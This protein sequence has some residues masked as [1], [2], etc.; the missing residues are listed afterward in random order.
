MHSEV[1]LVEDKFH[2]ECGVFGIYSASKMDAARYAYYG[3]YALQHRGQGSAGI[4][5][6][7]NGAISFYKDMGL[8]GEIF[9]DDILERLKGSSAVGH[10]RY[11][12][13]G[14]SMRE[15]AQPMV[16]KYRSGSIALAHNGN[17]VNSGQLRDKLEEQG[18]IFQSTIDSEVI[19]YLIS[20]YR[21][22]NENVEESIRQAMKEIEGSYALIVLTSTKLV[23]VRDPYGIRPLCVGK[24]GDA[25]V[26]SSESCAL[27]AIG[28]EFIRDVNPG[29]IVIAE[30]AGLRSIQTEPVGEGNVC[31]FEHIYF[32]RPDSFIDGVS[33]NMARIE[34][35][36]Q[37]AI[38]YPVDADLVTGVPD[39]G[40]S[41]ALGYSRQS[42]IPYG[43]GLIKNRY[44][45]RTFIQSKKTQRDTSVRI[46]LSAMK[47]AVNGKRVV[48]V[49]DS[50]VRG[51]TSRR[52]VQILR[53]AGAKEV[54]MRIASP[55]VNYPCYF[56]IDTPSRTQLVA[57][58]CSVEEIK[59]LVGADTLGYLT[60]ETL[61]KTAVGSKC[62]FCTACFDGNYPMD[63]PGEGHKSN[64]D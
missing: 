19:A 8:V 33:V 4:A 59:E 7:D 35:G 52:I 50:I 12:T 53:D 17:L 20:K 36:R 34:A 2:D 61:L 42:G 31:I 32:A 41:A 58:R 25:Y 29:E 40:L 9:R 6:C 57:S 26:F 30:R 44:I 27:D 3:L 39:S 21:T 16:I 10:V 60:V 5:V 51:T 45:G 14:A 54:H 23:G 22:V 11:S 47:D 13:A 48:L 38:M 15:N 63:I 24:L 49:D 1:D 43:Q 46:K 62:G 56:G 37:L 64:C 28:A 55:P 18:A